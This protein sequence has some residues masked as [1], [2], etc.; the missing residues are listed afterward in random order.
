LDLLLMKMDVA[1]HLLSE[2]LDALA[3]SLEVKSILRVTLSTVGAYRLAM[4][5]PYFDAVTGAIVEGKPS[6]QVDLTWRGALGTVGKMFL[7]FL[8]AG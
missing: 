7:E 6:A 1:S 3:V 4:G 8:E 5:Q 2:K